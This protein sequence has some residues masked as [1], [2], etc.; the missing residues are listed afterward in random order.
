MDL[1]HP[2]LIRVHEFVKDKH[3][4]YFVMEYFP[5]QH[6]RLGLG[7][8][9]IYATVKPKLHK[10]IRQAANGL[11]YMHD[12]GWVH[13]DIKP[14][15]MIYNKTAELRVTHLGAPAPGHPREPVLERL[16]AA[17]EAARAS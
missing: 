17:R 10:L 2:N 7:K 9:D 16:R 5:S 13:R 6:L 12:K 15:N 3:Q 8:R 4:P 14:E 1:R 11:A